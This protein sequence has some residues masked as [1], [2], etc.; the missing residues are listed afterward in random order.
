MEIFSLFFFIGRKMGKKIKIKIK[1]GRHI[2]DKE[3]SFG[4]FMF[5]SIF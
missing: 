1:N 2:R 3:A 5:S 4:T